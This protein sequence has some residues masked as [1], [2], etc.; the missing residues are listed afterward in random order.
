[1]RG[2]H[3]HVVHDGDRDVAAA[4]AAAHACHCHCNG[5]RQSV[6]AIARNVRLRSAE[7]V[8]V[9]DLGTLAVRR[10]R[11]ASDGQ[12]A[13]AGVHEL[14][15][16][17]GQ[18]VRR[19]AD[20]HRGNAVGGIDGDRAAGRFC[21]RNVVQARFVD[22]ACIAAC[23]C[24]NRHFARVVCTVDGE[25]HVRIRC[26][27][28]LVCQGV[29][30][31]DADALAALERLRR[32]LAVVQREAPDTVAASHQIAIVG[33][34]DCRRTQRGCHRAPA[35]ASSGRCAVLAEAVARC[36]RDV[37]IHQRRAVF[38]HRARRVRGR[39]GHV[40]HDGDADAS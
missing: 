22:L 4:R 35:H 28:V 31:R 13:L 12:H 36:C 6:V 24:I 8:A 11:H 5:V 3:G 19:A 37:A 20:A 33:Q 25:A 7:G 32:C 10:R 2:R 21:I 34:V 38:G 29:A 23:A 27:A 26:V 18:R 15:V 39:H 16:Q 14:A 40:V 17:I 1:M 30:Q 9:V